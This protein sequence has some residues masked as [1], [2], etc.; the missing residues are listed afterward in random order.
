MTE[1]KLPDIVDEYLKASQKL[2]DKVRAMKEG[3]TPDVSNRIWLRIYDDDVAMCRRIMFS[4]I[5]IDHQ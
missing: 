2:A 3:K 5:N 1:K 4:M